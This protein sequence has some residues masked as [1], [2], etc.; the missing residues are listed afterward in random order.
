MSDKPA[1]RDLKYAIRS[2]PASD[3]E[4]KPVEWLWPGRFAL[5]AYSRID[6]DPGLGK[7]QIAIDMAARVTR[8]ADWPVDDDAKA[9][10]GSVILISAED[11][12][13][14]V[15]VPRL[16]AAGAD[17]GRV[18]LTGDVFNWNLEGPESTRDLS[19][20]TDANILYDLI[21]NLH[22][23]RM[24]IIDPLNAF[25]GHTDAHRDSEIRGKILAPLAQVAQDT[26]TA[27]ISIGHL[28]KSSSKR[29]KGYAITS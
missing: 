15:I 14:R 2:R 10:V 4:I 12:P 27:I 3:Y 1:Y 24:V 21:H 25:L 28:N 18:H 5:G 6:G 29:N 19:L 16:K 17:L 13:E 22:Y 9:E 8:G 26:N 7:S 23:V 11:D 20:E